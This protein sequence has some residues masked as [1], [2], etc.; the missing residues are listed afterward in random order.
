MLYTKSILEKPT[1]KDGIRICIMRFIKPSYKF[2]IWIPKL[3]PSENLLRYYQKGN[4]SWEDYEKEYKKILE[5]NSNLIELISN[6]AVG[7]DITLL[8]FE[9]TPEKCHRRL[10]AEKIRQFNPNLEIIIK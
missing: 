5:E 1:E 2:D 9:K 8:C 6:Q 10:L 3:A 4:I 7:Y